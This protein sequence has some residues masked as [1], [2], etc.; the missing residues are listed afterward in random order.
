MTLQDFLRTVWFGRWLVVVS[1]LAAGAG[2]WYYLSQQEP[3]Y[4]A[5]AKVQLV[6]TETLAAA[7]LRLDSDPSLSVSD[8][9]ATAAATALGDPALA[10]ELQAD[11][12]GEYLADDPNVVDISV[13][14][15]TPSEAVA[16]VNA[17]AAAYTAG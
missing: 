13:V 8:D 14:D 15:E 12:V 16:K 5:E 4:A 17:L 10:G 7:G 3:V 2:A 6:D 11:A 1:V 9:V